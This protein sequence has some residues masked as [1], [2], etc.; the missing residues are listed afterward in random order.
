VFLEIYEKEGCLRS[1]D[2]YYPLNSISKAGPRGL[3]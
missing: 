3:G 2:R 1:D